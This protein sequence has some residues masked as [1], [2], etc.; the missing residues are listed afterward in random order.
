MMKLP[1]KPT[2]T[3]TIL[4][5]HH[6]LATVDFY[7]LQLGLEVAFENDWF[8]E[9]QLTESSFLSVANSARAT[10]DDVQGQ[11]ITLAWQVEDVAATHSALASQGIMTTA[12]KHKWNAL[13]FYCH[14]PEGHRLEFWEEVDHVD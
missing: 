10:I 8:I 2:R 7:R 4:Y 5:C 9:F 6:W 14:D 13:V 12:I 1:S 3:N 11:G